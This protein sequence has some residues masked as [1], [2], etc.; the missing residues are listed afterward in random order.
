MLLSNPIQNNTLKFLTFSALAIFLITQDFKKQV[1]WL[2][3][4]LALITNPIR[5]A[6]DAPF[7]MSHAGHEFFMEHQDLIKK[8]KEL[9]KIIAIYSARDQNYRS[10][11]AENKRLQKLLNISEQ[12]LNR[13]TVSNILTVQTNPARKTV[14]IDKGSDDKLYDGQVA[15]AGNSIYGQVIKT[16]TEHSIVVQLSDRSHTIPVYNRRTG[17]KALAKGTGTTNTVELTG[18]NEDEV[19]KGDLYLS[20]GYG[21]V[22][23]KDFPVARVKEK[24]YDKESRT[25]IILARTITDYNNARELLLIWKVKNGKLEIEKP[26]IRENEKGKE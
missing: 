21:E 4:S 13:Y 26:T 5:N 8:N 9:Q 10:I 1:P 19:Q 20:S 17:N 22:F 6:V 14:T 16:N 12:R 15:L 24:H 11:A 23:P 25:P 2:N 18:V 3:S 7:K